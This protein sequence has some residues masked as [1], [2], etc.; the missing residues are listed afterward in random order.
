MRSLAE[1][2]WQD[3]RDALTTIPGSR[4]WGTCALVYCAFL[5]CAAPIGL[6]SGLLRPGVP[7]LSAVQ[8]I[9]GGLLLF[10][11]PALFEE[12]LFRGLLLPRQA[13]S[14]GRANLIIVAGAALVVYVAS[15]PINAMLFRPAA[16]ALFESPVYLLL[17]ALLGATCTIAYLISRSIWP[18]VLIHWLTVVVWI[19]FLGGQSLLDRPALAAA[20]VFVAWA[21]SHSIC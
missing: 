14:M 17:A 8:L 12:I 15:H 3:L 20:R 1:R 2:R 19:W 13:D 9:G 6:W 4:A 7:Q 18:P 5:V 21:R 10:V 16:L 11:Q